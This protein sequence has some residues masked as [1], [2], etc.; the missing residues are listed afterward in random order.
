ME[1][2]GYTE[3]WIEYGFLT[4]EILQNQLAEFEKG[5]D[6]NTEHYRYGAF[7]YW[8]DQRNAFSDTEV[9]HYI[10]LALNDPHELMAGSAIKELFTSSKITD[11][12]YDLIKRELP[13]FGKW[14]TKLIQKEEIKRKND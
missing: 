3:K 8:F 2:L 12:Q 11:T 13:K 5:E 14:T 7:L 6:Q 10:E 4:E 9:E 1:V